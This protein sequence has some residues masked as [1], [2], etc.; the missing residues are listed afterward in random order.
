[1]VNKKVLVTGG[2]GYI[3]SHTVISLYENG[4]EP[5]IIDNI[6][7]SDLPVIDSIQSIL[8]YRPHV[9]IDE[10][11]DRKALFKIFSD[12]DFH[13]V[14]HFA[15]S[16]YVGESVSN[17]LKYYKNNI[18]GIC[19]LISVMLD[20]GVTNIV[21]SSSCSVYGDSNE[22]PVREDMHRYNTAASP[23]GHTKQIGE[24]M[25][26]EFSRA[27]GM[28]CLSLRYFNPAG[29]HPSGEI[30]ELPN[31]KESNLFPLMCK[32]VK[33][34][35][36]KLT[37][38]GNDYETRDGSCIRDFIH[39]CDLADAHVK[40]LQ[41][42]EKSPNNYHQ[43]LNIGTGTGTSVLECIEKFETVNSVKV[44]YEIGERRKGDVEKVWADTK[45]C[46]ELLGWEPEKSL[47]DIC[48]SSFEWA[49][50]I[51]KD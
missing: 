13:G 19:S 12:H 22:Q 17:P 36:Y 51:Q 37:V 8:D 45:K 40:S 30:G 35:S 6:S 50:K 21:F 27:Y 2:L 32:A 20:F 15:A 46:K 24:T 49:N 43:I 34:P 44:K 3:G 42:L 16:K 33:D 10:L 28:K 31:R 11:R 47:E 29:A 38:F 5:I 1:M 14:I 4:F 26:E 23:Y 9:Y 7:N 48:R 18:D 39:V 41:I 25:F